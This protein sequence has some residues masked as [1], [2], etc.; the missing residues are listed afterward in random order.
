LPPE[1]DRARRYN[2]HLFSE[3]AQMRNI[4]GYGFQPFFANPIVFTDYQR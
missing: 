4:F 1:P 3:P 2:R